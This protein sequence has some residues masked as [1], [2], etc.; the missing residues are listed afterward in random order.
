MNAN[1]IFGTVAN[2][3]KKLNPF[4]W[5]NVNVFEGEN[6]LSLFFMPKSTKSKMIKLNIANSPTT[7]R[8]FNPCIFLINTTGVSSR[9]NKLTNQ[10]CV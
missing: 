5:T 7:V 1:K 6:P 10:R 4:V 8:Y 3:F 9:R 2:A